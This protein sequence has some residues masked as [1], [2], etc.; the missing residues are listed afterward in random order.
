MALAAGYYWDQEQ[1][2]RIITFAEKYLAP[3]F[4]GGEFKLFEWQR[5]T[6]MSLV[7]L[8][9]A[10]RHAALA[11]GDPP[12]PQEERQDAAD[13]PRRR[14]RA[15][16]R[17]R[18]LAA[19]GERLD[20]EG[21]RPQVYEHLATCCQRHPEAQEGTKVTEFKKRDPRPAARRREYKALSADAPNAEGRTPRWR[22]WTRRTPTARRS[23]TGPSSTR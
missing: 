17:R 23:C 20:H 10:R 3:K 2:E 18:R 22:S 14:V 19:G 7:R 12:R 13:E 8:A 1:A 15:A 9:G 5:R 16:R 4:T 6:L 11:A 21:Q